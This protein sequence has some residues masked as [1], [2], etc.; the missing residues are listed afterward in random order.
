MPTF[1]LSLTHVHTYLL[2]CLCLHKLIY[3]YEWLVRSRDSQAG[4]HGWNHS[5]IFLFLLCVSVCIRVRVCVCLS[6]C[7]RKGNTETHK[8]EED[9]N[10]E[11]VQEICI[12]KKITMTRGVNLLRPH[13]RPELRHCMEKKIE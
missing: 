2:A 3:D 10:D 8:K 6:V 12:W 11:Q 9:E 13:Q 1:I 7:M 4:T 5:S